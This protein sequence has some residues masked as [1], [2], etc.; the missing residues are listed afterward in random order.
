MVIATA[1]S[2]GLSRVERQLL[3]AESQKYHCGHHRHESLIGL[4]EATA[5]STR[6]RLRVEVDA[7]HAERDGKDDQSA[8]PWVA[9]S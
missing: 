8:Q 3:N 7:G 4:A 6:G 9:P 1:A 5:P 2:V